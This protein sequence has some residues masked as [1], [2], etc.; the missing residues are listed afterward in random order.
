M[1]RM[2]T[3]RQAASKLGCCKLTLL[4]MIK[5]NRC[6]V[7]VY[8]PI[9]KGYKFKESEIDAFINDSEVK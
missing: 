2:L 8:Q 1:E 7:S 6:P 5:S 3:T 4:R 9:G